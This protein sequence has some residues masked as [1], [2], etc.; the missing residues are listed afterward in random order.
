VSVRGRVIPLLRIREY[1]GL[2]AGTPST[3][4]HIAVVVESEGRKRCLLVDRLIGKQEVV[5]KNLGALFERQASLAGGAILGDGRVGLILDPD[6]LV[7]LRSERAR[8]A[9]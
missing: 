7:K 4:D 3:T 2:P 8:A 5:I 1:F 6:A 9:A